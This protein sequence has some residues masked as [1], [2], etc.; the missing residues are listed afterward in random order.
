MII[1]MIIVM[2]IITIIRWRGRV[3][4]SCLTQTHRS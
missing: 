2:I 4:E 3:L 1:I